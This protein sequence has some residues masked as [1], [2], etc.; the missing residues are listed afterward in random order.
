MIIF[1]EIVVF[2]AIVY[3]IYN[4]LVY[5]NIKINWFRTQKMDFNLAQLSLETKLDTDTIEH[6]RDNWFIKKKK[7]FYRT[8]RKY[9]LIA[10][11]KY[12]FG[13]YYSIKF[14]LFIS[15][16][17]SVLG[18]L[19]IYLLISNLPV[20]YLAIFSGSLLFLPTII[21]GGYGYYIIYSMRK[22][23]PLY[24]EQWADSIDKNENYIEA[25]LENLGSFPED[26]KYYFKDFILKIR[27]GEVVDAY[28]K[29]IEIF[30]LLPE[31]RVMFASLELQHNNGGD[32]KKTLKIF[33]ELIDMAV[34][35]EDTA[36]KKLKRF[37]LIEIFVAIV[38]VLVLIW[39]DVI[40]TAVITHI[41]GIPIIL[42]L[43][44]IRGFVLFSIIFNIYDASKFFLRPRRM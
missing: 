13:S 22:K 16:F 30:Y 15:I 28:D 44:I 8:I 40:N 1:L 26:L 3:L 34:K 18:T 41:N 31:V 43:N 37:K 2:L 7:M 38:G 25:L 21:L 42:L 4:I 27:E 17:F 19:S 29:I 14:H 5:I 10:N 36:Y 6:Y 33:S 23:M 39:S 11:L 32:K 20:L 9:I 35:A 24:L 12:K